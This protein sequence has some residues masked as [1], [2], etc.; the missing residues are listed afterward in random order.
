MDQPNSQDRADQVT[1]SVSPD[2]SLSSPTPNPPLSARAWLSQN[3]PWLVFFAILIG[4]VYTRFGAEMLLF[5]FLALIGLGLVIFIHELGHFLAAKW[6]DV[7]VLTFSI[8]FGP[9]IPGCSFTRGE[10]TYKLAL[11]PLG[12]YVNMVGEGPEADEDEDYPRS[13]KNKTVGQRMLIISAGVIM[14][15]LFGALCFVAVYLYMGE[16]RP[17]AII[18][19]TE[20]GSRAW[21]A[22]VKPGWQ[23]IQIDDKKDPYFDDMRATVALSPEGY[24][25]R[26]VFL[27]ADKKQHERQIEPLRDA[28]NNH[29]VIGVSHSS[30]TRLF[31]RRMA[32]R[33]GDSPVR[34][35]S[36]ASFAR[37][38]AL[39][40]DETVLKASDPANQFELTPLPAGEAGWMELCKRF[41][42]ATDKTLFLEVANKDGAVRTVEVPANGFDF[43]DEI[44]ATTDP[45]TPN[46]PFNL[47]PLRLD[48][49]R[50]EGSTSRDPFELRDRFY[51]LAGKP[52]AIEVRRSHADGAT[53]QQTLLV[54]PAFH[55]TLG[56]RMSMGKVA[57]IRKDSPASKVGLTADRVDADHKIDGDVIIG[58]R[59]EAPGKPSIVLDEKALDPVRLPYELDRHMRTL[60]SDYRVVLTVRGTVDHNTR[61]ER[62]LAPMEWDSNWSLTDDAPVTPASPMS[63]P[64]LG[65]AYWVQSTVLQVEPHSPAAKAGI[66]PGDVIKEISFLERGRKPGQKS[67]VRMPPM[68]SERLGN[69]EA[70][71]QWAHYFYLLQRADY[72]IVRVKVKRVT[73]SKT[74]ELELPAHEEEQAVGTGT[75]VSRWLG[76]SKTPAQTFEGID[77]VVDPTWPLIDR[78]FD[79]YPDTR[80]HKAGSFVEALGLGV[81]RTIS[82]IQQIYTNLQRLITRRISTKSLG[83][84]I[85][86]GAQAI[87]AAG[88]SY[89]ALLMFLGVISINLAVVNFLPIPVL[90]GGHMVFLIYEKLRG[91]PPS[92]GVRIAATYLGLA[93]ILSLMVFVFVLDFQR[94]LM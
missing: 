11:L 16:E 81:D 17:P 78:G 10:T 52:M 71:D 20:A 67:W 59:L 91:R 30:T 87:G 4:F 9:A 42:S 75:R 60:G 88:H 39:Q 76:F 3:G 86:I 34:E 13:F 24:Q 69:K 36:A 64:Q 85:E 65:I 40:P 6:C 51:L 45:Q 7:H 12:G 50:E 31:P 1:P 37:V 15:V 58:A 28:N 43:D 63:I 25:L 73:P 84:P 72:P 33:M 74:E 77:A 41:Q 80:I 94:R 27:D 92:E 2:F 38:L 5:G 54:P 68:A 93:I 35:G 18:W 47:K 79:F 53:S 48:P 44:I 21:E 62:T 49:R 26:F 46:Q 14:N 61:K 19:R 55:V 89:S 90:D 70:Y 29:P 83:G 22:G 66:Q 56:L 23:L 8:G 82:F 57:S 32:S